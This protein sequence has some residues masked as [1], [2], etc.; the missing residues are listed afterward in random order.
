MGQAGQPWPPGGGAAPDLDSVVK[1]LEGDGD[2]TILRCIG[3]RPPAGSFPGLDPGGPALIAAEMPM[4]R[5][6]VLARNLQLVVEVDAPLEPAVSTLDAA[7]R[8]A[9]P[10]LQP[11]Y[12]IS[13]V[14]PFYGTPVTVTVEVTD[15]DGGPVEGATVCAVGARGPAL[16][17][18]DSKG[19]AELTLLEDSAELVRVLCVMPARHHWSRWIPEPHLDAARPN[20]VVVQPLDAFFPGFPEHQLVGWGLRAMRIDQLPP[21]MQGKGARIAFIDSGAATGS[22]PDLRNPATGFDLVAG[23]A[24]GWKDDTLAHGT[25]GLG[26]VAGGR[27][28]AGVRG[29]APEVEVVVL[30]VLPGGRCSTLIEAIDRCIEEEVD[31]IHLGLT[32]TRPSVL[33]EQRLQ[34]ARQL[35]IACVAAAGN[36]AGPVTYPASSSAVLAVAAV[37]RLGE[38]PPD[39]HHAAQAVPGVP[40]SPDGFFAA[41]LSAFGPEVDV[42]GPGVAVVSTVPPDGYGAWD[43]TSSAAAHVSG[44]AALLVAHHP[45]FAGPFRARTAARVDRLFDILRR[46]ARALAVG[47]ARRTGFGLP[48]AL[49]AFGDVIAPVGPGVVWSPAVTVDLTSPLDRLATVMHQAGI[50]NGNGGNGGNGGAGNGHGTGGTAHERA[51]T[52]TRTTAGRRSGAKGGGDTDAALAQLKE[53]FERAGL[54]K[55]R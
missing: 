14:R 32:T 50:V 34:Q 42:C 39:S 22:H 26:V 16:G 6:E 53:T 38:F 5:A 12:D 48:D 4:A 37:G 52:A 46:S 18:T 9:P 19:R 25:H 17:L 10:V 49:V 43:G 28:G 24:T 15:P 40:I 51:G 29:I 41:R 47:D 7:F 35:G 8:L 33:L 20:P 45:D 31:V 2:V 36:T 11:G 23:N 27:T 21:A 1:A 54:W 30:K 3:P 55:E 13:V 44:L